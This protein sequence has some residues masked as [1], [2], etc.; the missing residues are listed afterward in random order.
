MPLFTER[1]DFCMNRVL[2]LYLIVRAAVNC[3]DNLAYIV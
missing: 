3:G 1:V 2:L